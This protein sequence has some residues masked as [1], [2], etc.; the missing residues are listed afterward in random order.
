MLLRHRAAASGVYTDSG[1]WARLDE[2]LRLPLF[3]KAGVNRSHVDAL[4]EDR[5]LGAARRFQ[6]RQ[7]AYGHTL[8]RAIQGHTLP[9]IAPDALGRP[10]GPADVPGG[11]LVHSAPRDA[12]L[13]G[14]LAVGLLPGTHTGRSQ[15]D[16]VYLGTD[17]ARMERKLE[18]APDR[19]LIRVSVS[20]MRA[21][22]L[23]FYLSARGDVL[24]SDPV[25]AAC[26]ESAT[27]WVRGAIKVIWLPSDGP[28]PGGSASL[29]R[30][31]RASSL[32]PAGRL[33][34]SSPGPHHRRPW[35]RAVPLGSPARAAQ[36]SSPAGRAAAGTRRPVQSPRAHSALV[37]ERGRSRSRTAATRGSSGRAPSLGPSGGGRPQAMTVSSESPLPSPGPPR[38]HAR[39]PTSMAN[40]LWAARA[41]VWGPCE[42]NLG[43]WG[44]A[45]IPTAG[46]LGAPPT[47]GIA[48]SSGQPGHP[49]V[50]S[51]LGTPPTVPHGAHTVVGGGALPPP[52]MLQWGEV[53]YVRVADA[54]PGPA[55][56]AGLDIL[57]GAGPALTPRQA[58]LRAPRTPARCPS[59]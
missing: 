6:F 17:G 47:A 57:S 23:R 14:D 32:A 9:H 46:M 24:S 3:R 40:A 4:G 8:V 21:L 34:A 33:D 41:P 44:V 16:L 7:D 50:A 54:F 30:T 12:W 49:L 52:A 19:V 56:T 5:S 45:A 36:D 42:A 43:P 35:V 15:R 20:T 1:G 10:V 51:Y 25:P 31:H 39:S 58:G 53:R 59:R 26:F 18:N 13:G 2:V 48:T 37:A 55:T 29:P 11:V 38:T 28:P 27:G 22:G